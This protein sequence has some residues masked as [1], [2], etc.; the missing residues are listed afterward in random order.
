MSV[1]EVKLCLLGDSGVGK[2]SI[3]HRF[4][5]D[6]FRPAMTSTIGAAFLTKTVI[7]DGTTYKYQIWD[8]AGQEKYRALA[9]MYYRGAAAAIIVYD[10]TQESSFRATKSWITEL[11]K[12]ASPNIVLAIAGNKLDLDDLRDVQYS[13][14]LSYADKQGTVFVETSAKSAANIPA[15]FMEISEATHQN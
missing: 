10:I 6:S 11:Q 3:V 14:A 1:H 4:V 13:T 5:Y 8:T 7:V 15:L 9:P 12:H 2:S